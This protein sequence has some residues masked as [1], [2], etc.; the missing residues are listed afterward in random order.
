MHH[1]NSLCY[2]NVIIII[3]QFILLYTIY[4]QN[5]GSDVL[6]HS[7]NINCHLMVNLVSQ[8]LLLA[9]HNSFRLKQSTNVFVGVQ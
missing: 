8:Y 1:W 4:L 9:K 7:N 6:Q 5:V 3:L 2:I